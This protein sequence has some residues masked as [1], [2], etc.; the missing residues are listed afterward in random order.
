MFYDARNDI[1][2]GDFGLAKFNSSQA[3]VHIPGS[4]LVVL[5]YIRIQFIL[6]AIHPGVPPDE[7]VLD[8][9]SSEVGTE[10]YVAPEVKLGGVY[11]AKVDLFSLGICVVEIWVQFETEMERIVTLRKC[12]EGILPEEMLTQHPLASRLA[13]ELL[14]N[15]PMQRPTAAEVS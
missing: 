14:A 3:G 13:L 12:R 9:M 15:D 6:A 11:G 8:A 10:L 5:V 4:V 2:L 1:K 7:P